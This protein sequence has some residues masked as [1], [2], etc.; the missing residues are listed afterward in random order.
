M[1]DRDK[2][3]VTGKDEKVCEVDKDKEPVTVKF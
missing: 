3:V 2:S 1:G